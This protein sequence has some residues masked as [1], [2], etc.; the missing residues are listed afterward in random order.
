MKLLRTKSAKYTIEYYKVRTRS[1][2]E[3]LRS[4][5]TSEALDPDKELDLVY[6]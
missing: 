2:I 5:P 3:L 6:F 1:F 4:R